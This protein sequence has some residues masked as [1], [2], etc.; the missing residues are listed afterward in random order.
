VFTWQRWQRHSNTAI[1]LKADYR[2]DIPFTKDSQSVFKVYDPDHA[3]I[4]TGAAS[5]PQ[6]LAVQATPPP[7]IEGPRAVIVTVQVNRLTGDVCTEGGEFD[8]HV[9]VKAKVSLKIAGAYATQ[10]PNPLDGGATTI[11]V[12]QDIRFAPGTYH[13]TLA[14]TGALVLPGE[15][16]YVLTA[17]DDN[18]DSAMD[19]GKII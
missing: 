7:A 3:P 15:Y 4:G 1:D 12:F 6:G 10:I 5:L 14:A 13:F 16:D 8:F 11:P 18:G 19:M 9:N 2:L 17:V